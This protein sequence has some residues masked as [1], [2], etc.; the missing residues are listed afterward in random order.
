MS[1]ASQAAKR[2]GTDSRPGIRRDASGRLVISWQG[3]SAT[4]VKALDRVIG[5]A[6]AAVRAMSDE[7][8]KALLQTDTSM[9]KL[10]TS[11]PAVRAPSVRGKQ[12]RT[13]SH[14]AEDLLAPARLRGETRMREVLARPDMLSV[15]EAEY[16]Y[17]PTRKTLNTWRAS[18]KLLA[19][20]MPAATRG[21]RYPAWQFEPEVQRHLGDVIHALGAASPWK[22]FDFLT[23]A[24]PLLGGRVPLDVLRTGGAEAVLRVA[25]AIGE[26]RQGAR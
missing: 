10:D 17:G 2:R 11:A 12:R 18:G 25:R 15:E 22:V 21:Y 8:L 9:V 5:D 1:T 26:G 6:F 20:K 19:L 14:P 7:E 24:Q 23:G 13:R 4:Q 3:M 16:Q